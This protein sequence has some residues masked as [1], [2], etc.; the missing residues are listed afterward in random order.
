MSHHMSLGKK[1]KTDPTIKDNWN[2]TWA[3]F[4]DAEALVG[5]F[6]VDAA[7]FEHSKKVPVCI[8]PQ[9][10][11]LIQRWADFVDNG[12]VWCNPPF[13]RKLE[14]LEKAYIESIE[15]GVRSCLMIPYESAT[16]WWLKFVYGRAAIVY[17][18]NGR[19]N[20]INDE[21]KEEISG[22]P[23]ASCFVYFDGQPDTH[24][25]QYVHFKRGIHTMNDGIIST[26]PP[27]RK[28]I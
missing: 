21:T 14:F 12:F 23:F 17:I 24:E 13:S 3:A 16:K 9:M 27:Q 22:V 26:K 20:F 25:T 2:T 5:P 15:N 4:H 1:T 7:S 28:I 11:S 8:T 10:D 6:D 19:Y 18:P